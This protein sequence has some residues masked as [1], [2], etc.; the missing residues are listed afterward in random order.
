MKRRYDSVTEPEAYVLYALLQ[1]LDPDLVDPSY[2][3]ALSPTAGFCYVMTEAFIH[4]FGWLDG[5]YRPATVR[6]GN[7]VHWY[8]T[9]ADGRIL[10]PTAD[11]YH[12]AVP[13]ADGRRRWFC[14]GRNLSRRAKTLLQRAAL[15]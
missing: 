13:Y 5:P 2:H 4:V 12:V 10:D 6:I 15:L 9:H 8:I 14:N 1:H 3:N 7:D 11:Q